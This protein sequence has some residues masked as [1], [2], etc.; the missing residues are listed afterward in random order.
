MPNRSDANRTTDPI[1]TREL[2][3][4]ALALLPIVIFLVIYLGNCI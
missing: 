4:N 2:K 1:E 3:P